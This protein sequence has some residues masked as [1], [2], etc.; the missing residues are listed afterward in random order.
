VTDSSVTN[1]PIALIDLAAQRRRLGGD[2]DAAIL[3]VVD[4]GRYIM[5]PEVGQLEQELSSFTGTTHALTCASGTDALV[6]ALRALDIA[7]GDAVLVPTFTFAA[8][9]EAVALVGA[10]PVF[11]DVA[12]DTFDLTTDSL[13]GGLDAARQAGLTPR[14]VMPVDLF[15]Q[16]ADYDAIGS[17]ASEAGLDVIAD[18][19]QSFGATWQGR[20][21]GSLAKLTTTSFFPA[22]PLGCYG[23]GGAVFTDDDEL[24]DR[25]RSLRVHGKGLHKYENIRVGTNSR[26]DTMQAAILL[27]KLA[28]FED[29]LVRRQQVADRYAEG[30]GDIV[31]VPAVRDG[32]TSAWAQ[33]TIVPP[34]D[35]DELAAALKERGVPTAI[36]YPQPLHQQR[37][38]ATFPRSTG[39]LAV[40]ESLS[41]RVLSLPMHPYLESRTQDH[42]LASV[43]AAV[44]AVGRSSMER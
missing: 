8:T 41:S 23:D 14:A 37:A 24:A 39:G 33:Y 7:A 15:G 36:Y 28:I 30:L 25:L 20:R 34:G 32:A 1:P 3:A 31:A 12:D 10:T 21:V 9:A 19:A 2:V 38:Y 29:E 42:V 16:P 27:Q 6:L 40:A 35:R 22:K 13:R 5:G 26:L 44:R 11:C 17:F 43:E 18:G 4:H